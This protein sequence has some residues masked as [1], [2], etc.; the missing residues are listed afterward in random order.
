MKRNYLPALLIACLTPL[1]HA[2]EYAHHDDWIKPS[3]EKIGDGHGEIA[4]AENG[5]VYLSVGTGEKAGI[6]VYAADGKY[7]RNVPNAPNDFHGFVIVKEGA[8]EFI[9][10][11]RLKKGEIIKM[12]LEGKVVLNI[13]IYGTPAEKLFRKHRD[14]GKSLGARLTSVDALPNGDIFVV[15]GYGNDHIFKFNQKGEWIGE[16]GGRQKAPLK[17]MNCHKIFIDHRYAEP[18]ILLCDR[19]NNRLVHTTL[20]GELVKVYAT[21]LR[22]P[23]S[24]A[25]YKDLVAIAEIDGRISVFNKEGEM[26]A[27]VGTNN[28]KEIGKNTFG[29]ETW[30]AGI[31]KAPH[32]IAFDADGNILMTEYNKWGRVMKFK[33]QP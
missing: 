7:L 15:D 24:A 17:L 33:V 18:R 21:K 20:D 13:S 22:K 4:V 29:P 27:E 26:V 19:L 5:E 25:F 10:G 3:A 31:V 14:T 11:A 12:T 16:F 9:Y 23:S 30:E 2:H 32:G 1:L 28:T 6:Q 8:Q